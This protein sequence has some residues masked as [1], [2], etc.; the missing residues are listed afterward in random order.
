MLIEFLKKPS[1]VQF[2]KYIIYAGLATL[3]NL[4]GRFIFSETM[5]LPFNVAVTSAYLIGMLVNF[6]L[7]KKY[8]FAQGPRAWSQ[9]IRS[10]TVLALLGLLLTNIFSLFSL[11]L[12]GK[13]FIM[14]DL[15]VSTT[16]LET[17]AHA[18]AVGLVAI[19]SFLGH[20]FFTFQ[21]GL[22][23]GTKNLINKL[24]I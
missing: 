1:I 13:V 23:I 9:E 24:K 17:S 2:T 6:L 21:H 15:A 16:I 18:I 4:V 20:K 22:R 14:M 5:H 8:T 12:L 7:N 10:F 11:Y 3:V 19:Y